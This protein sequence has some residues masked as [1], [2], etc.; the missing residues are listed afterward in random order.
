MDAIAL[1]YFR[2]QAIA[3]FT[4]AQVEYSL[5]SLDKRGPSQGQY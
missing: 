2:D 1:A 4:T 3:T 5:A